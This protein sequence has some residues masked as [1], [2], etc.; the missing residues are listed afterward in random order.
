MEP[1]MNSKQ[2]NIW[3]LNS[4][5][6][7]ENV[8][9]GNFPEYSEIIV[10][11]SSKLFLERERILDVGTGSGILARNIANNSPTHVIGLGLSLEQLLNAVA[12]DRDGIYIQSDSC[13]LPFGS[14]TFDG[15][16]ASMVLEHVESLQDAVSEIS[17]VLQPNGLF[18]TIL[19]HPIFQCPGS[20]LVEDY[21][22]GINNPQWGVGDY[23]TESSGI[24]EISEGIRIPFEHRTISTYI[25]T[26]VQHGFRIKRVLEPKIMGRESD[27]LGGNIP[28][29]LVIISEMTAFEII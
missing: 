7:F 16:V 10:P 19:N 13:K 3:D 12:Q 15:V 1:K 28:R 4:K 24:E 6:W 21:E 26:F 2:E 23:L 5:W 25:N 20:G 9:N 11:L 29:L 27:I 14:N 18:L 17:R 22:V 8:E